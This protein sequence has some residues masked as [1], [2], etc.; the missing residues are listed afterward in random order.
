LSGEFYATLGYTSVVESS[1]SWG[2]DKTFTATWQGDQEIRGALVD[3]A[4]MANPVAHA[5][6]SRIYLK[7]FSTKDLKGAP[8]WYHHDLRK[9]VVALLANPHCGDDA[10]KL[11]ELY[12]RLNKETH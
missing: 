8:G 5:V 1:L 12:D 2:F 3:A 4:K 11:A 10:A 9:I 7:L 6:L